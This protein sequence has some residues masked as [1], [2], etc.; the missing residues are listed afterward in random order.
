MGRIVEERM[1]APRGGRVHVKVLKYAGGDLNAKEDVYVFD[2][3]RGRLAAAIG[4][5]SHLYVEDFDNS[6]ALVVL[7]NSAGQP[8]RRVTAH[9]GIVHTLNI[10][11]V[12]YG[13]TVK[14]GIE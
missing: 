12:D 9:R 4:G 1:K 5:G 13:V 6:Q 7:K 10:N 14:L 3:Q 2:L 11:F 8:V